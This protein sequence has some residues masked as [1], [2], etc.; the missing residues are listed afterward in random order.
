[1]FYRKQ[2]DI[3][4]ILLVFLCSFLALLKGSDMGKPGAAVI[5]AEIGIHWW[6]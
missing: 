3:W 1:M 2:D 5:L 6:G 4:L